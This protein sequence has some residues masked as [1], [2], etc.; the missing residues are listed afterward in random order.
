MLSRTEYNNPKPDGSFGLAYHY[1]MLSDRRRIA[2]F[3]EAIRSACPGKVVLESGAGTGILSILAGLA[4]ARRVY[5]VESHLE[6]AAFAQRNIQQAGLKNVHVIE[7]SILEV[8]PQDLGHRR[9]E[10]VI[11]ENLSTWQVTEPQISVLNH[12]NRQLA[13]KEA[14]RIP[15]QI[16][17]TLELAHSQYH[18]ENAVELRVPYFQFSG[19]AAPEILS[20][21]A[22]F[23]RIDLSR[24]N[25]QAICSSVELAAECNGTLN[26]IRLTSPLLLQPGIRFTSSDSLMPPV[27][28][29]LEKD[30]QVKAGNCLKV[31]LQYK[32]HSSWEQFRCRAEV[33]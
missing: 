15:A 10:V 4:G 1:E 30:L 18:F 8:T 22:V 17:N 29:P 3:K 16:E 9:V 25:P 28:V 14:V 32:A 5:A 31:T 11:A 12:I 33:A 20:Q 21:P 23:T 26:S 6:V 24:I 13:G 19:T 27:V 7:K 2:A